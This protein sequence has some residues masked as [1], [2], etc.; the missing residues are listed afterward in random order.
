MRVHLLA[1]APTRAQREFRFASPEDAIEAIPAARAT[2]LTTRLRDCD[3]VLCAPERRSTETAHA[4]GLA[5]TQ[6][7]R[8]RAWSAGTW[9][10]QPLATISEREPATFAAWHTDPHTAPPGGESLTSLLAR[11]ADWTDAQTQTSGR[12][13]VIADAAV[14]RAIVIHVLQAPPPT[15]WRLEVP[16]LSLSIVQHA[17]GQWRLRHLVLLD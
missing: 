9:T 16:P 12:I 15:F 7:D 2:Q 5:A 3:P 1:P 17:S 11:A 10:G 4:L 14:L 8:L 13:V 6:T